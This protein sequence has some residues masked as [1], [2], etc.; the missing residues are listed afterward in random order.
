MGDFGAKVSSPGYDVKSVADY[1]L[2][3]S[4]SFPHIK[5]NSTGN[6][7]GTVTHG[8]GY[9]PFHFIA[10]TNGAVDQHVGINENY[11][12][13]T[14]QLVRTF[15]SG[16]PRYYIFRLSLTD[17][18]TAPIV[19]GGTTVATDNDD[20][21]LKVSKEGKNIN[22]TDMRDYS[23]HSST[24]TILLH[25]VNEGAMSNTGSGLGWERI[26]A[27][28]LG[29]TPIAFAFIQ[30]S[31]NILGMNSSRYTIIPPPVGVAGLYYE[32]DST[33]IYVTADTTFFTGSPRVSVVVMK[34]PY[35][36]DVVNVSYP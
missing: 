20:F 33:N 35:T 26:V 15:G 21:G 14:T 18:Y 17:N 27:H 3:F 25:K 13:S 36:K 34:D 2:Q 28:G 11:G 19:T 16:T 9:A 8:L 10:T 32:V 24:K 7:S 12:V 22:S 30:P 31:T 4:S 29:Y 5:I 1:L 6:F 23:T